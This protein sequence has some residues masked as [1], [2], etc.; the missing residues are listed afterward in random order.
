MN[1]LNPAKYRIN[2]I[3]ILRGLVMIIMALDHTRDFFH[4]AS[5]PTNLATTTPILFFTR[6]ITHFCAPVFVFLSGTSAFLSGRKKTKRQLSAFLFSR[7]L[8]LIG[9]ELVVFNLILTFDPAYSFITV[10][11]LSVIGFSMM[12][13]AAMIWLPVRVIF[14]VGCIMVFGHNLLDKFDFTQPGATPL[15]WGFLHQQSFFP[16]ANNRLFAILYPLV[17]WPG[18]MMLGYCLGTL[19]VKEYNAQ[20]RQKILLRL[21]IIVTLFFVGAAI[22]QFVW[23]SFALGRTKERRYYGYFIF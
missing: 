1:N 23:R 3:D 2:S 15:W 14:F 17:P 19:Y 21:G 9:I 10:Q 4:V 8:W 22:E 6:W 13:L 20:Q 18:V 11:I 5:D 16:Y 12:I 7:G